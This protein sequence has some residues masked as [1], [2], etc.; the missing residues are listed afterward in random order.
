MPGVATK[1]KPARARSV[2][3]PGS[4]STSRG[5]TEMS[6]SEPPGPGSGGR[7]EAAKSALAMADVGVGVQADDLAGRL[8][9]GTE[10]RVHPSQLGR[11]EHRRLDGHEARLGQQPIR[12]SQ[13]G[14]ARPLR[15]LDRQCDHGHARDLREEGTLRLA[16]G[17][18]SRT[19]T[20][21]SRTMNWALTRPRTP[22]ARQIRRM[23]VT[24]SRWAASPN[25]CGGKRAT[26]SP[27]W[28]PARSTC[29]MSPGMS[30][31]RPSRDGVDIDL[32][33]LEVGVDAHGS[34][35][36]DD[37]RRP[38]AGVRG[39]RGRSRTS[40]ARPPMT[41]DGRTRTG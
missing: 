41:N 28:T 12:P 10:R 38:P 25:C 4:R 15:H 5:A 24:M 9:A 36:A 13:V 29:S 34:L 7:S 2:A 30:T 26:L 27:E 14:E 20:P 21:S 37:R 40:M 16:R 18:T 35:V 17:F 1:R 22:I 31:S 6:A 33:P 23:A 19:C 11:R 32:E 39:P 3:S 8:H